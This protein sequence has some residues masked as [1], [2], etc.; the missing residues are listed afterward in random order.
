MNIPTLYH[1]LG[2]LLLRVAF[3]AR[4]IYGTI[5]NIVSWDRMLEFSDFLEGHGFI[6]STGCAVLSVYAQFLAG[7][8]WII[9]FKV[10]WT[11]LIMIGNFLVALL[12]VHIKNGDPYL[13]LAPAL[14][15]LVV[16]VVLFLIGSGNYAVRADRS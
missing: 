5:D 14:H 8:C 1:H 16:S 12:F 15:L 4:L 7:I 13:A 3:G 6:F 10:R 2:I 9:G 11:S